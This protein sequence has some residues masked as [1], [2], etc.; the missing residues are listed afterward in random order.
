MPDGSALPPLF[1]LTARSLGAAMPGCPDPAAWVEALRAACVRFAVTS[2]RRLAHFVAQ[3]GHESGDLTRLSENLN[4]SPAGLR[5][6]FPSRVPEWLAQ[7]IGRAPGRK[8][9]EAAICEAVYGGRLGNRAPG[10]AFAY[11][12]AGIIQLTGLDNHAACAEAFGLPT[13]DVPAFLRT[14]AGAALGAAWW[15]QAHGCNELADAG[16]PD[17][18]SRRVNGG[19]NGLA[20]RRQRYALARQAFGA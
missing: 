4:Y 20:D 7:R 3:V 6:V 15:W 11:R 13:C 17:A 2:P 12:G 9:D 19:D 18:V 8:A 16:D 10:D 5:A 1:F 14:K